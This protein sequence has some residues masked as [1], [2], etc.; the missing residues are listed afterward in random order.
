M[1]FKTLNSLLNVTRRYN[2]HQVQRCC[3]SHGNN[4]NTIGKSVNY[5][6]DIFFGNSLIRSS[7]YHWNGFSLSRSLISPMV[8]LFHNQQ[9]YRFIATVDIH[10]DKEA[11]EKKRKMER[12]VR[13]SMWGLLAFFSGST[14][15]ALYE[16]GKPEV[17]NDGNPILDEFSDKPS[18]IQYILRTIYKAKREWQVYKDPSRDVLLPPPLEHPYIQPKYTLV[19]ES[20][21]VLFHPE[22]TYKTG[23]RFKKRPFVDYFLNQVGPPLFEVVVFT[24]DSGW[25]TAGMIE[26]LDPKANVMHWLFRDSTRYVNGVRLKDLNGLNRDLSKVIMIDWEKDACSLNPENCLILNKYEGEDPDRTLF[27]LALFLRTIAI[28]DVNDVR[29]II[30]HYQQFDDPLEV[31]KEN[32]RLA[33]EQEEEKK[34]KAKSQSFVSTF[35]R[36]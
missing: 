27:E 12:T 17:D 25:T 9:S 32:Q 29:P 16:W 10:D 31:F 3:F 7:G 4:L 8:G 36:K 18:V 33:L 6:R 26:S 28:Q 24:S 19:L 22:W 23:W 14:V 5:G 35:K 15:M 21:G 20:N 13:W 1:S 2:I 34:Q 30:R 11:K